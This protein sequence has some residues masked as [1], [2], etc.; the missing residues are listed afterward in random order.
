[1]MWCICTCGEYMRT[2]AP[3]EALVLAV[4][5]VLAKR[6]GVVATSSRTDLPAGRAGRVR[7]D[8]A[9]AA[10]AS[11]EAPPSSRGRR[12]GRFSWRAPFLGVLGARLRGAAPKREICS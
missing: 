11:L 4:G 9:I 2:G 10:R 1:M 7:P 12:Q 8:A 6:L 3:L 5:V